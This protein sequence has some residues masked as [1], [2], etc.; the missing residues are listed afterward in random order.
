MC[1]VVLAFDAHAEYPLI[2]AGNR[3]EF[4]ARPTR[5]AGWWDDE[6]DIAG[7]RDL[8]AGGTWLAVHRKGRFATVTNYRGVVTADGCN[9]DLRSRGHLVTGFLQ[10]DLPPLEYLRSID[11]ADYA[12]FN[13]LVA[14]RNEL[15]YCSN[16]GDEPRALPA[17][18]YGLGNASL[19]SSCDKVQ[20]SKQRMEGLLAEGR[21]ND[22]KLMQLLDERGSD[23]SAAFVV[24]PEFGTRCSTI[25]RVDRQ[26]AWRFLE[27][28]FDPAGFAQG[29]SS[30]EFQGAWPTP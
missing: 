13:L 5:D 3:D 10:S 25:V 26:G 9:D 4:H 18:I 27:R 22:A 7:G 12:G 19:D 11:G 21:V 24:L 2:V 6:P 29:E 8:L 20:R 16:Q 30:L 15:A 14:D 1:L 17:G 23:I 28:R